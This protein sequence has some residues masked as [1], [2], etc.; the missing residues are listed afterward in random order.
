MSLGHEQ[1]PL[2]A[3]SREGRHGT[4]HFFLGNE[5]ER[6]TRL[7]WTLGFRHHG[8]DGEDVYVAQ[9]GEVRAA[10]E[11]G[12]DADEGLA[13]VRVFGDDE[14]DGVDAEDDFGGG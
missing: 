14:G 5:L 8:D 1:E 2:G 3:D 9:R 13:R 6:T 7:H 11:G 4:L 12:A 10:E